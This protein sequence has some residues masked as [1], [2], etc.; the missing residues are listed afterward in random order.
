MYK[1]LSMIWKTF[2][3]NI[4]WHV[5]WFFHNKFLIG[6]S[7]IILNKKDQIL[8]QK[9]RFWKKDSWGLPSGYVKQ[10]EQIEDSIKREI[11]EETGLDVIIEELLNL[12]SGFKLRIECTYIGKCYEEVKK[13]KLNTNEVLDASFF[14]PV[15]LPDGILDSH[16]NLIE[17]A[18][19]KIKNDL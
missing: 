4:K 11:K 12:N 18:I 2:N 3:S 10:K 17:M 6:T 5:L 15:N 7:A 8:L 9:H 19:K 1:I 13:E 14:S 16:K